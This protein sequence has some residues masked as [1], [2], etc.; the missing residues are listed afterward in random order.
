MLDK[1]NKEALAQ[2]FFREVEKLACNESM[3]GQGKT[4]ALYRLLSMLF[5]ELTRRERLQFSTLFARIAYTC[6]KLGADK[7]LQYYIHLFRKR[8]LE[9]PREGKGDWD[10][11]AALG[12][13]ALAESIQALLGQPVPETLDAL[14]PKRWPVEM[15]AITFKAYKA[16]AR[17]VALAD[18]PENKRL[19]A[20]DE[21]QP[22][23]P[24][25]VQYDET[26]RNENFMPTIEAIRMAFGFPVVL[27]LLDVTVDEDGAY[28]PMAI[29][30]EPDYLVDVTAVAECFQPGNV[31]PW[32][33]L[34]KKYLPFEARPA[35]MIGHIANFFLDELMTDAELPFR[36]TFA[37]AFE[38]NPLAFCLFEDREVR[39]VMQRSQKHFINLKQM[40]T[41]GFREQGIAPENCYLEPSFFSE[42]Y[43]LQGRL[44]VLYR[45]GPKAAIV[46]LKSGR[47]FMPNVYGQSPNHFVQTLLYDLLV[48]S[49]FGKDADPASYILYSGEDDKPLRFAPRIKAQQYEALQ[50]RNQL[51]AIE[52][53]L[54][55]LGQLQ[56]GSLMEQGRRL[57]G[58][59][60][61]IRQPEAKGFL[62]RDFEFFDKVFGGLDELQMLYFVAFSG[63]IARE[64]RLAKTGV[65]GL[66]N[67]N[68]LA[69]LWLNPFEEKQESYEIISHLRLLTNNAGQQE[70]LVTFTKT[71]FTNPLANFREGDIAVLYPHVEGQMAALQSQIFKCTIIQISNEAVVVR[72]RSRQ[73][74]SDIFGQFEFWNLEHDLLDSS[75][76]GMYRN[77]FAFARCPKEKQELLLTL[78][79]PREGEAEEVAVP[80]ELTPEQQDIFCR[81][82]SAPDYFLLWGPPGT[83]KTSMMLKHLVAYLLDNTSEN[84]LLLAY[85]NRAVD[86]ICE[87]LE[88]IR[89][90]IRRHYLRIGSRYSTAARFQEQ[91]LS[92]K[93]ERMSTRQELKDVI[94]GHRIVVGTVSSIIS[95]PELLQLKTFHR[96]IID[97]ASQILEPM[98]VGLLPHF[99]RFILIGDHKQLPAVVAQGEEASLVYEAR[100]QEIGLGNL[101]NSL[102]ERLYKRCIQFGWDYAYAQLSHQGRMHKDIMDFPNRYFYDGTLKILPLSLPA[103][104]KQIQHLP[105]AGHSEHGELEELLTRS[106]VLFIPTPPDEQS[107]TQKTNAHEAQLIGGLVEAFQR[108]YSRNGQQLAHHS[109]GIITPYRAQIAQIRSVL[110]TRHAPLD[111]LTIDTVERYQGGARDIILISL[112]TNSL[113]QMAQLSSLSEDGVDRKLNVALTRARDHVVV[114]GNPELLKH[115]EIYREL[116]Q[117]CE[118]KTAE[119]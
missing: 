94:D 93:A 115:S 56:E 109:I 71:E 31:N 91:L 25:R 88:N 87:A 83:G 7:S 80:A 27:N 44:D 73:F 57:F 38:L 24:V 49:A 59:L 69:S 37:R 117:Y 90:D 112:C 30:V 68:G 105:Y 63:F 32:P 21:E 61:P 79:P 96:A 17:V 4:E 13:K 48:R 1:I 12:L 43:G 22:E 10:A 67:A 78:R 15:R 111:I 113:S 76:T 107:T 20:R 85:T 66:Y 64:H 39:E 11:T 103:H 102:F 100:L 118:E 2:L 14:L 119:P 6:H 108:I 46:E 101:R 18:D 89:Q 82:L 65:Q 28:H 55:R 95:R 54:A 99:E 5:V 72:L 62:A 97:E 51:V 42:T 50:V 19:V 74:N 81:A 86:E 114:V 70:P 16:K 84:I 36:E 60:N 29:V 98:L 104:L 8:A 9:R 77:L 26:G 53:L 110:E 3:G 52:W 35:L 41:Q 45:G 106:R 75:F 58:R 116:I 40:V 47:P 92:A 33:Y 23:T 34:L